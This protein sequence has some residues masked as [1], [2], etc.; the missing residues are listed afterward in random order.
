LHRFSDIASFFVRM[1]LF[2]IH[3]NYLRVRDIAD[4]STY[5]ML[6]GRKIIFEAFQ[7]T[8]SRYL[9]ITDGQADAYYGITALSIE[10]LSKME[11]NI[12]SYIHSRSLCFLFNELK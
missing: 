12:T 10:S 11:I 9:N 8:L 3:H 4:L 1:T 2:L 7:P 5:F 6:F